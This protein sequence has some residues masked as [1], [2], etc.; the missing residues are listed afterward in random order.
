MKKDQKLKEHIGKNTLIFLAINAI[1]GTGIFF[2]PALG[3]ITAGP[4]S[5]ISWI[6]MSVIAV[7]MAL[8]FAEL[9]SMFPKCG[10]VYEYTKMA[11]GEFHSFIFG[12]IAWIVANITIAMLVIGSILYIFPGQPY[13]FNIIL[14]SAFI[15]IF[16]LVSYRGISVSSK[17]L[18][19]FGVMTV[20]TIVALIIP[21]LSFFDFRNLEPFFVGDYSLIFL[22]TFLIAETFFGWETVAYLSEEVKDAKREVPRVLV[23]STVIIAVLSI[24]LV[25]VSLGSTAWDVFGQQ[26]APLSFL[27]SIFFGSGAAKIFTAVIFIPIIGTAAS[28]IVSSPRLLYAMSRDNVLVPRFG[29]LHKKYQTPHNA[30]LFQTLVT[31]FVTIVAL[32]DFYLVLSLLLPLAVIMYSGV[33]LSVVKLRI[34]MPDIKRGFN[35]PFPRAGPIIIVLFNFFLLYTWLVRVQDAVS[36]FLM[37]II[38]IVIGV[39]L[40]VLI[41]LQTDRKFVERFFNKFS[42][43]QDKTFRIWYTDKDVERIINELRL[44]KKSVVLDFGC[45]SGTTTAALAKRA[46]GGMVIAVDVSQKQLDRAVERI[47]KA[48]K[49]NVV[50][51]KEYDLKFDENSFDAVAAVGVLEYLRNPGYTI[52]RLIKFLRPGGRFAFLSFGK[53]LGIPAPEYL[54]DEKSIRKLFRGLP[55]SVKIKRQKKKL[56]EYWFIWGEKKK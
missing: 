8:Y 16:S 11:F 12:W 27:A 42:F 47:K 19:F 31:I 9:I 51:I 2:L 23:L 53:S 44:G 14:S 1:L 50:L 45:G 38:L 56:V 48:S 3:A 26:Q 18:L 37:G 7:F 4:A 29:R 54:A 30:I 28:W 55:V 10:G 24:A 43:V 41:K 52:Q 49:K 15:M 46:S 13:I 40:Y 32:G 34:S 5:I 35:A 21:G 33:L 22:A 36:V 6:I 17:M 25:A 39:P 20:L